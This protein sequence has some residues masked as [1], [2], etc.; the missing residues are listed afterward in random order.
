[1]RSGSSHK[2]VGMGDVVAVAVRTPDRL[3]CW[4]ARNSGAGDPRT[5]SC[6][7][8][9]WLPPV[10]TGYLLLLAFGRRG[11]ARRFLECCCGI[12]FSFRW[13]G[14]ALAAAVMAFPL[15]VRAIRLSIEAVDRSSR[16]PRRRSAPIAAWVF[17]DGHAAARASRGHRRHDPRLRQG[18]RR[19]RRDHHLRL[20]HPRRDPDAAAGDLRL[21]AGAGRR[22]GACA[23]PRSPSPCA[24]ASSPP[25]SLA[26]RVA[27]RMDARMTWTSPFT[28]A[29][30]RFALDV[31]FDER[32]R[33]RRS[34]RPLRLGQDHAAQPH[35]RADPAAMSASSP[36][37]RGPRR[38]RAGIFVPPHRRRIGYVFQ[39]SR[40]FPHLTV[41]RN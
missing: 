27:R 29:Q 6:T 16:R 19:V 41:R 9:W 33:A 35:R 24:R 5:A 11:P 23:Q 13:T 2:G 37:R 3:C 10:V 25:K 38:Q 12:V 30:G 28:I 39:D 32:A 40:L 22:S 7:C 20:E 1:M 26:R 14:A 4:R 34:D 21:H 36:R 8:R 18:P 17:V 31:A 15:M